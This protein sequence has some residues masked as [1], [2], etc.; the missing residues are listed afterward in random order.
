MTKSEL[1]NLLA[2]Y[3]DDAEVEFSDAD[4][5]L[6]IDDVEEEGGTIYLCSGEVE[7]EEETDE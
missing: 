5:E 1:I 4:G 3:P 7:E 2:G 6:P